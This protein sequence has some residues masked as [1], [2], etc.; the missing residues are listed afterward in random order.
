MYEIRKLR[1]DGMNKPEQ[2]NLRWDD[3]KEE[4][5]LQSFV[6]T[7]ITQDMLKSMPGSQSASARPGEQ[8]A[9]TQAQQAQYDSTPYVPHQQ[10]PR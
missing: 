4:K 5:E 2:Q 10:P 7:S 1:R 6:A 9:Q 8:K 3:E